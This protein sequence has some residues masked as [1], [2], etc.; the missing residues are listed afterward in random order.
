MK[1][2]PVS[3]LPFDDMPQLQGLIVGTAPV[4]E[5]NV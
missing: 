5:L 4:L 1:G 3:S 2:G